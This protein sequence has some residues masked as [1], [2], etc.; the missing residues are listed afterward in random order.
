[1]AKL[2]VHGARL[3]CSEGN[4]PS[5]L[6]VL[7]A[8][9]TGSEEKP[10]AT[11]FDSQP[12]ANIMPFGLC[13]SLANPQVKAATSAAMGTLT[14]QPCLP[15][16]PAPWSPGSNAVKL[17]EKAALSSD[18]TCKCAWNGTIEVTDPAAAVEVV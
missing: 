14:P 9:G 16:I 18:S 6:N 13:K 10:A 8:A 17:Q 7:P 4:A 2:V 1:M 12:L 3:K 11:I 5:M 15:V